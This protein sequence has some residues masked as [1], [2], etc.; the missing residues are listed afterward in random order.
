MATHALPSA[1]AFPLASWQAGRINCQNEVFGLSWE[2]CLR[3]G[4]DRDLAQPQWLRVHRQLPPPA[5]QFIY[6]H[7]KL[8]YVRGKNDSFPPLAGNHVSCVFN[9]AANQILKR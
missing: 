7:L 3:C 9:L 2:L 8:I 4:V 1:F 5:G 6:S